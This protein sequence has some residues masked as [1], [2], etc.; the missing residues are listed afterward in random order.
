MLFSWLG[1]GNEANIAGVALL[2]SVSQVQLGQC[3]R[4]I[5]PQGGTFLYIAT[6][7]QPVSKHEVG[8][9]EFSSLSRVLTIAVGMFIP[10]VLSSFFGHEH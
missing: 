3:H 6:V 4:L 2:L 7:I 10:L 9:G 1:E 8:M 5:V